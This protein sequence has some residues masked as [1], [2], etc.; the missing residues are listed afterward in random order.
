MI[1]EWAYPRVPPPIPVRL[2]R[3]WLGLFGLLGVEILSLTVRFDS[4]QLTETAYGW[5]GLLGHA[6]ALLQ[7]GLAG[8]VAFLVLV[9]PRLQRG[10]HRWLQHVDAHRWWPPVSVH[11]GTFGGFVLCT[12]WVFDQDAAAVPHLAGWA[13][14]WLFLGAATLLLWLLAVAPLCCWRHVIWRQYASGLIAS[15]VGLGVWG[16]SQITQAFW[17]PL[18]TATLW[19]VAAL[20]RLWYSDVDYALSEHV[21]GTSAFQVTIAPSCSGYE[22]MGVVTVFLAL[23]LWLFRR[24]LRFPQALG[25]VPLGILASWVANAVRVTA[26]IALGTSFSPAIALGG[27]HSQAGWLAFLGVALGVVLVAHQTPFFAC[28]PRL[29]RATTATRLA[30]AL[31]VPLLVLLATR[32][33]TA[34]LSQGFDWLYPVRV[35]ATGGA[36][37]GFRR[38]YRQF[39]WTWSWQAMAIGG[40]VFGM[41]LLLASPVE[42]RT[43]AVAQGLTHL[44]GSMVAVWVGFRALGSVILVPLAEELAF[45]GYVMRK[46]MAWDFARVPLGHWTWAAFLLSSVLF[47]AL[48]DRWVAG[49][50]AGMG[51]ALALTRRGQLADA[52]L[53]HMTTNALL[54]GYVLAYQA[55]AFWS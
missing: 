41:W 3:R 27:F 36:L 11:V 15:L 8:A 35:I 43:T 19:V 17:P 48:H 14:G 21:V 46:L 4:Q 42:S 53:A 25:L 13:A 23:Y 26:L 16:S 2:V 55:W 7:A 24:H 40:L 32:T 38:V 52:V 45:R 10:Q 50:L 49:S 12:A 47:G 1:R 34:A 44:S 28:A 5:L 51:Y 20:L 33:V 6:P 22:G 29:P 54:A 18:A 9:V 31:L 39:A 30:T 37:W